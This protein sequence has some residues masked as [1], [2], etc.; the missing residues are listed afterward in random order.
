MKLDVDS[1]GSESH[2]QGETDCERNDEPADFRPRTL[3][4]VI[5]IN[6]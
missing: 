2:Q 1:G 5:E 6:E 3:V 4:R